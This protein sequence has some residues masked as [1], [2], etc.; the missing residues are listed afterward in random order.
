ML[1]LSI[2]VLFAFSGFISLAVIAQ[3]LRRAW[4]AA[5]ELRAALAECDTVQPVVLRTYA[6]ERRVVV[7]AAAR[8]IPAARTRRMV[9]AAPCALRAAA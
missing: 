4:S 1:Q 2:A 3:T 8:F 6:I 9:A 5:G 7:P